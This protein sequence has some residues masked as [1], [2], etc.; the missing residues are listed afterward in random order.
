MYISG[1]TYIGN[2]ASNNVKGKIKNAVLDNLKLCVVPGD[3]SVNC[4]LLML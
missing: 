1:K 4:S 3:S 2:F